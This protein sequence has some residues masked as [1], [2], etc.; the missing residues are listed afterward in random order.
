MIFSALLA[1]SYLTS[2]VIEPAF[3]VSDGTK[4]VRV[5]NSGALDLEARPEQDEGLTTLGGKWYRLNLDSMR[6]SIS[7]QEVGGEN[8]QINLDLGGSNI[9]AYGGIQSG[10]RF[11]I[12]VQSESYQWSLLQYEKGARTPKRKMKLPDEFHSETSE[13]VSP[14]IYALS[15]SDIC[16]LRVYTV[17]KQF[18]TFRVSGLDSGRLVCRKQSSQFIATVAGKDV[19]VR[20]GTLT[21]GDSLLSAG[22]NASADLSRIAIRRQ[23]VAVLGD[24]TVTIWSR[25][26]GRVNETRIPHTIDTS[27]AFSRIW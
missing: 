21:W 24:K 8:S 25:Q 4:Y 20:E 16:F 10:E 5:N 12:L 11:L 23:S 14:M 9:A 22:K 13:L 18:I 3:L 17:D 7:L 6:E 2:D 26:E 15:G 19:V 27:S 1:I